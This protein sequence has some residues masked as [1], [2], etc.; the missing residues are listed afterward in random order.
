MKQQVID[1]IHKT[2]FQFFVCATGGGQSF[3]SDFLSYPG[4][5]KNFIGSFIPYKQELFDLKIGKVDKY[6]S[7]EAALRMAT[8][9]FK[10]CIACGI[11]SENAVGISASCSLATENER[12]GRNHYIYIAIHTH[13]KTFLCS[14]FLS[15]GSSRTEEEACVCS[16]IYKIFIENILEDKVTAG[17]YDIFLYDGEKCTFESQGA[18]SEISHLFQE[19]PQSHLICQ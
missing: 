13:Q 5:S 14:V 18:N 17:I 15:Q 2:D 1:R 7:K 6:C 9:A 3:I 19:S 4:A 10:E 12:V 11:P 8:Y 16:L